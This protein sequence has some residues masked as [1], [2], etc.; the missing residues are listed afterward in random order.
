V[1]RKDYCS[2]VRLRDL[3]D[4]FLADA[5]SRLERDE[6]VGAVV[7]TGSAGRGE[8]D[9]WS[10]LDI[11]VIATDDES[12]ELLASAHEAEAH[13]DLAVWVDCSF[14]APPGVA[15]RAWDATRRRFDLVRQTL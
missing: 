15:P 10:D 7:L 14:N 2:A 11:N 6:R 12:S 3:H 1:R 8:A 13:G 4:Q 5:V 9:D